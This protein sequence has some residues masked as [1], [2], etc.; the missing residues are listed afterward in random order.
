[1]PGG[2]ASHENVP[3]GVA[4]R[5]QGSISVERQRASFVDLVRLG[6]TIRGA[7]GQSGGDVVLVGESVEDLLPADPDLGEVDLFGRAGVSLTW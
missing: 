2:S 5:G 3:A 6:N 7:S 1:M 4:A